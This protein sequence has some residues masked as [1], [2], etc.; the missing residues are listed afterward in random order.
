MRSIISCFIIMC[1]NALV[2][3][4]SSASLTGNNQEVISPASS[5][6]VQ[7]IPGNEGQFKLQISNPHKKKLELNIRH[8]QLGTVQDK[9]IF[10]EWYS[11]RYNMD[12]A[13]DGKYI[14]TITNGRERIIKEMKLTTVVTTVRNM[15]V[16]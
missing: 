8:S 12:S 10:D 3:S 2:Y 9:I 7:V 1:L 15:E 4:Q 11:C 6:Y 14:I 13:D 5:F 16:Q